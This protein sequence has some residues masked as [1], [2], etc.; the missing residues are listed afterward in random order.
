MNENKM[1]RTL[2]RQY[3]VNR[4]KSEFQDK[5]VKVGEAVCSQGHSSV[6]AY[7]KYGVKPNPDDFNDTI[8]YVYCS[9]C[10]KN[11]FRCQV[12]NTTTYNF[13]E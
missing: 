4:I 9:V 7:N 2:R 5:K 13:E 8:F 6:Q 3:E 10:G 11:D 12:R 1:K